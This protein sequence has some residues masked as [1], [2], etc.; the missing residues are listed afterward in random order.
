MPGP[1]D[2]RPT[3]G[4]GTYRTEVAVTE[5]DRERRAA[6]LW[7][8][9]A[10]GVWERSDRL[11]AWFTTTAPLEQDP[12]LA[13]ASPL[14]PEPTQDWQAAWKATLSPV[15]A[16]RFHV[17]PSWLDATTPGQT[18]E[19]RVVLDP[20]QAFGSGH[21]ATTVLCLEALA[22]TTLSDRTLTDVGCG[23][24]ILAIAAARAGARCT[25]VDLD[26]DAVAATR[27][28]A[29]ANQVAVDTRTGSLAAL[30]GP[31]EVVVANL[32]T[33]VL[34]AL[35]PGLLA[36]STDLVIVSGIDG[37]RVGEVA[38]ALTWH[39]ATDLE[40]AERDGWARIVARRGPSAPSWD[41][42]AA[43]VRSAS[44]SVTTP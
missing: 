30:D 33:D 40:V 16:G 6:A 12:A 36:A 7:R 27:A 44:A 8:A 20:G 42:Q 41:P 21:H 31:A 26:A 15:R 39:G 22:V 14:Q 35:A 29:A 32:V 43:E 5:A 37:R 34:L 25:A 18:G 2:L 19:L 13:D 28:N 23:T 9:G 24:G 1:I 10:I 17:V 4:G 11:V 3:T 38:A